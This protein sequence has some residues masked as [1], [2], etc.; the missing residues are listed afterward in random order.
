ME[1]GNNRDLSG[2]T[3]NI[4]CGS[5]VYQRKDD[6]VILVTATPSALKM[7]GHEGKEIEE[8]REIDIFDVLHLDDIGKVLHIF[9]MAFD[10]EESS[11]CVFRHINFRTGKYVWLYTSCMPV[12]QA[13]GQVYACCSIVDINR[14]KEL[15]EELAISRKLEQEAVARLNRLYDEEVMRLSNFYDNYI[16]IIRYNITKNRVECMKGETMSG[17]IDA[18]MSLDECYDIAEF[19]F[20]DSGIEEG[21]YNIFD[22]RELARIFNSGK[23]TLTLELP[24]V[25]NKNTGTLWIRFNIT[26]KKNPYTND[27]IVFAIEEDITKEVLTRESF[28]NVV[29]TEFLSILCVDI[30]KNRYF[31]CFTAEPEMYVDNGKYGRNG[32]YSNTM[33]KVFYNIPGVSE[34][35]R[36]RFLE[37]LDS[38]LIKEKLSNASE[39]IFYYDRTV[40]G[41]E[42]RYK[43]SIRWLDQKHNLVT[44]AKKDVTDAVYEEQKKEKMLF[45]FL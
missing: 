9:T 42:R 36:N 6:K 25:I 30:V 2:E 31:C 17:L 4:A 34:N 38:K 12:R 28:N 27:I 39:Y 40:D 13:D 43:V 22:S 5:V 14:Q 21:F 18:G 3:I 33:R 1:L 32:D 29:K 15:E 24:F 16:C 19:L 41:I 23:R 10:N 37:N 44:I 26:M 45:F 7:V 11:E 20:K 35:K 8:L